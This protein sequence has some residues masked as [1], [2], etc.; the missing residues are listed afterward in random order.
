MAQTSAVS[1]SRLFAAAVVRAISEANATVERGSPLPLTMAYIGRNSPRRQ[2]NIF[3]AFNDDAVAFALNGVAG[4]DGGT[5][6]ATAI[7]DS[8]RE[9][10]TEIV[11]ITD[12]LVTELGLLSEVL[13]NSRVRVHSVGVGARP[14][15]ATLRELAAITGGSVRFLYPGED[16]ARLANSVASTCLRM[17]STP[18]DPFFRIGENTTLRVDRFVPEKIGGDLDGSMLAVMALFDDPP[19]SDM[20][21]QSQLVIGNLSIDLSHQKA[22]LARGSAIHRVLAKRAI[23]ILQAKESEIVARLIVT[24]GEGG[25]A[26]QLQQQLDATQTEIVQ[27]GLNYSLVS[28]H[29]SFLIVDDSPVTTT[30]VVPEIGAPEI[31]A[32]DMKIVSA[33]AIVCS[34]GLRGKASSD[35]SKGRNSRSSSWF[36]FLWFSIVGVSG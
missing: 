34:E 16:A 14:Y 7:L 9:G 3:A 18:V 6:V 28:S 11:F 35:E 2:F 8:L 4:A 20:Y 21:L 5:D 30:L 32:P 17:P 10:A 24:S 13:R 15:R 1:Q 27:L 33:V 36:L 22:T 31:G 12:G 19:S 25:D 29:T 26:L 23:K